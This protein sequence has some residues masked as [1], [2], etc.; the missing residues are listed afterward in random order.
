MLRYNWISW[1]ASHQRHPALVILKD[2]SVTDNSAMLIPERSQ[3][4]Y[5]TKFVLAERFIGWHSFCFCASIATLYRL[6]ALFLLYSEPPGMLCFVRREIGGERQKVKSG[7]I[8]KQIA[9][10]TVCKICLFL[11]S[12]LVQFAKHQM[13]VLSRFGLHICITF[14]VE[15]NK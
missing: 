5:L 15:I 11:V 14:R 2:L 1:G 4:H 9:V 6:L 3:N 12:A 7:T 13:T 10:L 8:Y